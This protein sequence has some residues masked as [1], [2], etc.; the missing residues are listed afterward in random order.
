MLAAHPHHQSLCRQEADSIF[1]AHQ[2]DEDDNDNP[3]ISYDDLSKLKHLER[4]LFESM[5]LLP[6]VFIFGRKL[7][8]ELTLSNG[9]YL[10]PGTNCLILPLVIHRLSEYFEMPDIFNPDNFLPE[11]TSKRHAFAYLPYSAGPRICLGMK[12]SIANIKI[13]T[14]KILRRFEIKSKC[15][16]EDLKFK[17][18]LT[19]STEQDLDLQFI[20]RKTK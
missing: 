4:C 11:N 7:E 18:N 15:E 8:N 12:S 10:P 20:P 3:S 2:K 13:V 6:P 9:V 5:R 14:A 1:Q 19:M 17:L 16:F